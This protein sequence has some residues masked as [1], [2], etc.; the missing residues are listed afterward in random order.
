[1]DLI[2]KLL[3]LKMLRP[4]SALGKRNFV[5]SCKVT[6]IKKQSASVGL[7]N[8]V[9]FLKTAGIRQ[10]NIRNIAR[11][12]FVTPDICR[13]AIFSS[14]NIKIVFSVHLILFFK[15]EQRRYFHVTRPAWQN[16]AKA[17]T[18]EEPVGASVSLLYE[19]Y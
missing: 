18:Y 15:Q 8:A 17:Y 5:V 11:N 12:P 19:Y 7:F 9:A 3:K 13:S 2:A 6:G 16:Q 14:I 4:T 1:M 10:R